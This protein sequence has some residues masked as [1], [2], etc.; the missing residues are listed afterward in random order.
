MTNHRHHPHRDRLR[1]R[2]YF[3]RLGP[4][5]VTGAADDDPSGI[6]TY[7]QIGAS[8]GFGMLWTAP[9]LLPFAIAVQETCARLALANRAG[10]ARIIKRNF[11][12]PI[13]VLAVALVVVANTVNIAA[14][15][16]SMAAAVRLLV[17]LPQFMGVALLTVS[18]AA[19]E[20]LIPYHRY[21]KLLRWLCISLLAYVA[22]LFAIDVDWR[23]VGRAVLHP[24][25]HWDRNTCAAVIALA[26]TTISPYLFVWQAAEEVEDLHDGVSPISRLH[27]RSMRIDVAAGMTS[28]VIIMFAIMTTTGTELFAHGVTTVASAEA[29]ADAL[30]PLAGQFAGLV[31]ALGILGTGLLAVPVLAGA[32]AYAVAELMNWPESLER[33]PSRAK[34]FYGVIIVSMLIAFLLNLL[35]V[36]PMYGLFLAAVTNGLA[37]PVLLLLIGLLAGRRRVMHSLRSGVVSRVLVFAT[38]A[39]MTA[40]PIA[41]LFS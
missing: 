38:V 25:V 22:V 16:A 39:F 14:D 31:F 36:N 33:R 35:Q 29:A 11:P 18:I 32:S 10:L 7:A 19:A 24:D 37:A 1:G 23:A 41:W 9:L 5:L 3:N 17:P 26:G 4:G 20:I 6:G 13:V 28:G 34:A 15:L 2:G 40:A 30:R 8:T 12:T 27:V 21:A